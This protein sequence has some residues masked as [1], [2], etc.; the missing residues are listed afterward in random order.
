MTYVV[1]EG[2]DGSGKTSVAQAISKKIRKSTGVR[3]LEL[4][5]PQR[6][7]GTVGAEIRRRL[8]DG[9]RLESW[10][11]VGLFNADRVH[12]L[13]TKLRPALAAGRVV[14]QDR[15]YV[16]TAVYNGDWRGLNRSVTHLIAVPVWPD[17]EFILHHHYAFMPPPDVMVLLDLPGATA[18]ARVLQKALRSGART[19][20]PDDVRSLD[21]WGIRYRRLMQAHIGDGWWHKLVV[22][23]A[24]RP[25]RAVVDDVW[26]A[27]AL[28]LSDRTGLPT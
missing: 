17:A 7:P 20:M 4:C 16:S 26:A 13:H 8:V 10:E 12:Q 5:E 27:V 6:D 24:S 23:D 15:S 18:S 28:L 11:A 21:E 25:K 14:V 22:I 19:N 9:P 2:I 3:P 1:I